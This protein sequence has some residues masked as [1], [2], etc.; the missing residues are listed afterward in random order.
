MAAFAVSDASPKP[1]ISVRWISFS[2]EKKAP[3]DHIRTRIASRN[4]AP[5]AVTPPRVVASITDKDSES[6][7]RPSR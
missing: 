5:V 1:R 6:E 7:Q 4:S 3:R 2:L